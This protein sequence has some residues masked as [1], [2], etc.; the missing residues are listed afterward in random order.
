MLWHAQGSRHSLLHLGNL[1]YLSHT[2]TGEEIN[3]WRNAFLNHVLILE[4]AH[5]RRK[6]SFFPSMI[7]LLPNTTSITFAFTFRFLWWHESWTVK[8]SET[9]SFQVESVLNDSC[10]LRARMAQCHIYPNTLRAR[11]VWEIDAVHSGIWHYFLTCS[12][13]VKF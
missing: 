8:L 9:N 3:E 12:Y 7:P 2:L 13:L 10:R 6:L 1:F 4:T 5:I 11:A